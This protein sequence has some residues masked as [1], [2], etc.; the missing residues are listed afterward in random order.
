MKKVLRLS[1]ILVVVAFLFT[2]VSCAPKDAA[3][4]KSKLE[5]KDYKVIT[6]ED[7]ISGIK[8]LG[9][10]LEGAETALYFRAKESDKH[11]YLYAILFAKKSQAK[12]AASK[13]KE[14]EEKNGGSSN[15]Q[16]IGK[17]VVYGTE[18]AIKDF[19]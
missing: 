5:K 10:D 4:A 11:E 6:S 12:D 1:S 19:K 8:A 13:M 9:I 16:N 18:Q 2:L 17:W 7:A 14:Y 3:A 15:V